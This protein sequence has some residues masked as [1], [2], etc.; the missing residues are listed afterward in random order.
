MLDEHGRHI[1]G[2]LPESE[3]EARGLGDTVARLAHYVGADKLASAYSAITG[4]DCG[5]QQRQEAL[6]RLVPYG[7]KP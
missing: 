6:N 4:R 7:T 5:C 2:T 1:T 3:A